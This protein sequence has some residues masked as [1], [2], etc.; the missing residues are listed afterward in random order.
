MAFEAAACILLLYGSACL[1]GWHS[2]VGVRCKLLSFD[3]HAKWLL[4]CLYGS[5]VECMPDCPVLSSCFHVVRT[6]RRGSALNT[7][8][9]RGD[10]LHIA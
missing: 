9:V 6:T 3:V 4:A 5:H 7:N 2:H 1:A 8:L 10:G